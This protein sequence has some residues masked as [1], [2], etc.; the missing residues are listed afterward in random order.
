VTGSILSPERTWELKAKLCQLRFG[1]PTGSASYR[2]P[3]TRPA[4]EA[5]NTAFRSIPRT[6]AGRLPSVLE[7]RRNGLYTL[8]ASAIA[9]GTG[10][11]FTHPGGV[12]TYIAWA[13]MA[14]GVLTI[15][16]AMYDLPAKLRGVGKPAGATGTPQSPP[17]ARLSRFRKF[18]H[19]RRPSRRVVALTA[20]ITLVVVGCIA[21]PIILSQS[22]KPAHKAA[23]HRPQPRITIAPPQPAGVLE[24]G[25]PDHA[26]NAVAFGPGGADLA[27]ADSDSLI[28]VWNR[29]SPGSV[30]TSR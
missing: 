11:L 17:W 3:L 1:P 13:L 6:R 15:L 18:L 21:V 10:W 28:Y 19:C 12:W 30:D 16:A 23:F 5:P 4:V 20:G 2:T 14:A 24:Q 7:H 29:Q 26:V 22:A 25:F 8:G 9:A 27:T